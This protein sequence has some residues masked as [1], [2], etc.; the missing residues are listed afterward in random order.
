MGRHEEEAGVWAWAVAAQAAA[1]AAQAAVGGLATAPP[2]SFSRSR[3][4]SPPLAT[5]EGR[6]GGRGEMGG[7]GV[8]SRAPL[9]QRSGVCGVGVGWG[10]WGGGWGGAGSYRGKGKWCHKG[11]AAAVPCF[12]D[13]TPELL[14]RRPLLEWEGQRVAGSRWCGSLASPQ[15]SPS[16]PVHPARPACRSRHVRSC[17]LPLARSCIPSPAALPAHQSTPLDRLAPPR[18]TNACRTQPAAGWGR[19]SWGWAIEGRAGRHVGA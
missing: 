15:T 4:C 17:T 16:H 13:A 19:G 8:W 14:H 1:V 10:G 9:E 11:L 12:C 18:S 5:G 3:K 7:R 6:K 2:L